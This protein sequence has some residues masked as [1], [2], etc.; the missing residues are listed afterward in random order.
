MTTGKR[1]SGKRPERS[2]RAA[3]TA[4]PGRSHRVGGRLQAELMDLV[5]RGALRDPGLADTYITRVELTA[6]LRHA[7]I[8]FRLTR[9]SLGA[10]DREYALA[11]LDRAGGFIRKEL[12]PKLQLQYMPDLK[13][14][15]DD[16]LDRAARVE[17]MLEE[18]RRD[19]EGGT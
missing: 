11:A 18:I 6:D 12:G 14:F 15:W 9:P 7:R 5:I 1:G 19:E 3:P 2:A 13:F 17:A 8:Y 10:K 16:G 4:R